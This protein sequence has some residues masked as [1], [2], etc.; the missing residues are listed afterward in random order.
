M[1]LDIGNRDKG[2]AKKERILVLLAEHKLMCTEIDQNE[3]S[4]QKASAASVMLTP[5]IVLNNSQTMRPTLLPVDCQVAARPLQSVT[6]ISKTGLGDLGRFG[7]LITSGIDI[8]A[9]GL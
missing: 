3:R 8:E 5:R 1:G 4:R 6:R 9:L 2:L 7:P